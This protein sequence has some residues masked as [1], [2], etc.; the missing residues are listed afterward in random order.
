MNFKVFKTPG[1][2]R[3]R[4]LVTPLSL[5]VFWDGLATGEGK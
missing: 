4:R 1:T 2:T 3:G 5:L